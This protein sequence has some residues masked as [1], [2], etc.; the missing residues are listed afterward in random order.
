M[1]KVL[2]YTTIAFSKSE[3]FIYNQ[4]K[5]SQVELI[6]VTEKV[7]NLS[8]FPLSSP[9]FVISPVPSNII[10]RAISFFQRKVR[11]SGEFCL[12]FFNERILERIIIENN[13]DLVH[14]NYG[15]NSIKLMPVLVKLEIPFIVHFHG[16]D[17]SQLLQ[18]KV[19]VQGLHKVFAKAKK[20]IVVSEHMKL[21][22]SRKLGFN[23]KIQMIPY[24]V[25]LKMFLGRRAVKGEIINVLHVGRLTQKKGVVDL[26][27]SFAA[28]LANKPDLKINLDIVGEGEEFI[29]VK[30][31]IE[32]LDLQKNIILHGAK[33]H[34]EVVELMLKSHIFVLNSRTADNGDSEGFPNVI[35]EAMASRCAIIS[36]YH[37]GIPLAITNDKEGI[38]IKEKDN[39][40]LTEALLFLYEQKD[41]RMRYT[42]NA[43]IKVKEKFNIE[44]MLSNYSQIYFETV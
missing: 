17:A 12:S 32:E 9:P 43:F 8:I 29:I 18:N 26:V 10:D 37:A 3:T 22:L 27:K 4:T 16:F 38:L 15:I 33:S 19:Y 2:L 1:L 42:E 23:D 28:L 7:D 40:G 36:T 20:I 6:M 39:L 35:L 25:D 14:I 34:I 30:N 24:G 21:E 31:L 13:V 41:L 44:T 11:G 5:N